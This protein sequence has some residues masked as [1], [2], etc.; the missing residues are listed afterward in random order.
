MKKD[1]KKK[2]III[3]NII[4]IAFLGIWL[5]FKEEKE[6][7]IDK[8]EEEK[9]LESNKNLENKEI[10]IHIIGEVNN[11]GILKIKEGSRLFE[12]IEKAGGFT[13]EAN[14]ENLNLAQ[15]VKDQDQ[16]KINKKNELNINEDNIKK[17]DKKINLNQASEEE[18]MKLNGIGPSLAERI[19]SYRD[20]NN[21]KSIE[22][23]KNV[24]GIGE[25]RFEQIKDSIDV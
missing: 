18:L 22:E 10:I 7:Y 6:I 9:N 15:V 11:P 2:I 1:F 17:K 19:I 21:F 23:I 24:S 8:F 16:Y 14:Q 3:L 20:E 13:S 5:N 25:K 4:I 12:C